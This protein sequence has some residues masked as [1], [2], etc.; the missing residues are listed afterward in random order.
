[1]MHVFFYGTLKRAGANYRVLV[2]LGARFVAEATT[3]E[4]RLLVDLGPYPALLPASNV[5][6]TCVA[7]E[8][9]EI[10][11]ATIA[12]LDEFEGVP[13]LYARESIALTTTDGR[14]LTAFVYVLAIAPPPHA[15]PIAN[16][17]YSGRGIVLPGGA[18]P[19]QIDDDSVLD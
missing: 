13:S 10:D 4:P 18:S 3:V 16:G 7:G 6:A 12:A 14:H 1:M 9:F 17:R 11:D 8:V 2:D 15:R 19:D 5:G